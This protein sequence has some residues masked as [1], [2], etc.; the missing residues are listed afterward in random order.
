MWV[1]KRRGANGTDRNVNGHVRD[2][3][4]FHAL[5]TKDEVYETTGQVLTMFS[6]LNPDPV[7][8]GEEEIVE[9]AGLFDS[10]ESAG[11]TRRMAEPRKGRMERG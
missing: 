11:G 3:L 10:E 6:S 1:V 8:P 5:G 9:D 2:A 4:A 7:F